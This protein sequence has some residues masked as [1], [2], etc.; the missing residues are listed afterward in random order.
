M[1]SSRWISIVLDTACF[2]ILGLQ[3]LMKEPI[4]V[5]KIKLV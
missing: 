5:F 3:E 4:A 2:F 1:D